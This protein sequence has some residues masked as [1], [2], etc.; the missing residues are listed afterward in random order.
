M[1]SSRA[2]IRANHCFF[3]RPAVAPRR[4]SVR[5]VAHIGAA[6]ALTTTTFRTLSACCAASCTVS[7][8]PSE[9]PMT[10]AGL[11]TSS[12]TRARAAVVTA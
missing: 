6:C 8:A 7:W 3:A 4:A 5:R 9:K 1:N 10:V 11:P 2:C 12:S